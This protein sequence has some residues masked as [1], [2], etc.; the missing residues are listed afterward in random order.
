MIMKRIF[1][2]LLTGV[3]SLM[4][5]AQNDFIVVNGDVELPG[6][7]LTAGGTDCP[8]VVLVHGSGPNDRDETLGPNK[9]F[10][11]IAENLKEAGISTLRY[12]KRTM[13]YK[14]GADTLTYMGETVIDAVAA[15]RQLNLLGYKHIFVAGHSLGG[16]CIPLIAEACGDVLEG[17][18]VMSGNV[19]TM[20]QAI[21]SQ[22]KYIG[23]QQGATDMQMEQ[24]AKQMLATLPERYLEFDRAYSP[25]TTVG[26]VIKKY[27]SLRWLVI[28]GGHDYQVT[29]ADF[30][31][32]QMALGN[33]ATYYF[34]ETLDHI[35]RSLPKMAV[36]QDYLQVGD[37]D[38][39]FI[40]TL[41]NFV[42]R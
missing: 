33:K 14:E 29:R 20:E 5:F 23:Q 4:C 24:M 21:R 13:L 19:S 36:P 7:L 11:S 41:V 10:R 32:W 22:M 15:V 3:I 16:H 18:I 38:G 26:K 25:V 12:D 8:I 30:M 27:P 2:S 31:M 42:R 37:V 39:E 28:G 1:V 34:G 40:K 9:L 35:F 6:T 17:V